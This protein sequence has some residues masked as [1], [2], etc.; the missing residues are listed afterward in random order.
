VTRRLLL[1]GA[2]GLTG[3][4]LLEQGLE[5]GHDVTAL[6]R[7][8][9]RLTMQHARLRTVTGSATDAAA[10]ERA[11]DDRDAVLCALGTRSVR[12][13]VSCDL[14]RASM[15]ALVPAMERRGVDRLILLSAL[16]V[17]DSVHQAPPAIRFAFR[18]LLR[19]VGNDKAAAED[20]VRA[21]D[22]DWTIVYPPSLTD[23]PR[24][25]HRAGE[26][27]KL[28]GMPRISRADLADF[29]LSQLT[30][31][32]YSRRSAVVIG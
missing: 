16:G 30:D 13:L 3:R 17:G 5:Q 2:T 1:L 19:P 8:P 18:T 26:S 23:G 24:S 10:V 21:T 11:L 6:V 14:M 12:S 15:A 4:Q 25:G 28:R 31:A 22:L 27:L 20:R 9:A 32:A 29:M 7:D